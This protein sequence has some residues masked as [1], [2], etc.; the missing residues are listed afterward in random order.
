MNILEI[1]S[2]YEFMIW[3]LKESNI[4]TAVFDYTRTL[5]LRNE[6]TIRSAFL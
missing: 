6:N 4:D 2:N 3:T 5:S 1:C